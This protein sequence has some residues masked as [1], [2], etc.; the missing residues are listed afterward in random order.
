R[1]PLSRAPCSLLRSTPSCP[2]FAGP[3]TA[4]LPLAAAI[5]TR[6]VIDRRRRDRAGH[7]RWVTGARRM[8]TVRIS[9]ESRSAIEEYCAAQGVSVTAWVEAVGRRIQQLQAPD[10]AD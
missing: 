1:D 2:Q 10:P 8:L 3:P 4:T 6:S 5:S 9:E 7:T